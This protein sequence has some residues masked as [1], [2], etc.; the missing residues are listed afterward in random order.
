ML[1]ITA[2]HVKKET[3]NKL[4]NNEFSTFLDVYTNG[5]YDLMIMFDKD[6][7]HR[8]LR[9][10]DAIPSDLKAVITFC[11]ASNCEILCLDVN[12]VLDDALSFI[13]HYL[14]E[15]KNENGDDFPVEK[16]YC[17]NELLYTKVLRD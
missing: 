17:G 4:K 11:I 5:P 14:Y 8:Q 15:R 16:C 6:E 13:P 10:N 3:W 2:K 7:F 1:T 9:F 12:N